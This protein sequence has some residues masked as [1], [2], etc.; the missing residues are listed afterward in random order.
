LFIDNTYR[1]GLSQ[2]FTINRNNINYLRIILAQSLTRKG[3]GVGMR[4]GL[5]KWRMRE[6]VVLG[7]YDISNNVDL[8]T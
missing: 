6:G 7:F 3:H 4:K 8:K 1:A 5:R 2:Q